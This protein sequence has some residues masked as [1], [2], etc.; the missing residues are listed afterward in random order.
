MSKLVVW[1]ASARVGELIRKPNGNLEFRYSP[2]YGGPP[3][4]QSLPLQETAHGHQV[5]RAVFGGLLPEGDVR[6]ALARNLG[7]SEGNDYGLLEEVGGDVAGAINLLPDG[8][9]PPTAP[10]L[11]PLDNRQLD[12]LLIPVP[13]RFRG[14]LR[15]TAN[16]GL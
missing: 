10:T 9:E 13:G 4:S 12:A 16:P 2:G 6:G 3:V 5:T 15:R 11:T 14:V 1:I 7:V 8:I